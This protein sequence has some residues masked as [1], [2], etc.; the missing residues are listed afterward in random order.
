MDNKLKKKVINKM[1]RGLGDIIEDENTIYCFI[2]E[3]KFKRKYDFVNRYSVNLTHLP[4]FLH[5]TL[6]SLRKNIVYIFD[7]VFFDK[8][9]TLCI[10]TFNDIHSYIKFRNCTFTENVI[11]LD[12]DNLE[13]YSSNI[14]C[15]EVTIRAKNLIMRNSTINSD[16]IDMC[17]DEINL[18]NS[19]VNGKKEI[20]IDVAEVT[21]Y[22]N[23]DG[24]N[25]W[26]LKY[27]KSAF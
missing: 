23:G 25:K 8:T 14:N 16:E 12:C 2:D 1:T 4:V 13:V 6:Y 17:S 27:I 7:D 11:I 22:T 5:G 19:E 9:L 15:N 18:E 26:E 10:S 21:V 3:K 20:R 24:S